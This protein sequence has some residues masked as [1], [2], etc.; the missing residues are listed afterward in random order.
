MSIRSFFSIL[1]KEFKETGLKALSSNYHKMW[2]TECC[3][4]RTWR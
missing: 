3:I 1:V 2:P 4:A